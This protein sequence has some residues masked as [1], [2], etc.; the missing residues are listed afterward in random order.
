[1]AFSTKTPQIS[2]P[3]PGRVG[4]PG[5]AQAPLL[6]S[7]LLRHRS[8][9]SVFAVVV[10]H[11]VSDGWST[12]ILIR[13]MAALYE[14]FCSGSHALL[15]ELP[16]QYA[17]FAHWQRQW[18]QGDVLETQLTYW[19]QQLLGAPLLELPTDH[20]RPAVQTF[21][22]SHQS[23][24][25]PRQV[26]EG[27]KTL[28]RQE[29]IT[30]FMTL[31][32]AYQTLLCRYSGQNDICVGVP[33]AG[34]QNELLDN[35][36][37]FFLNLL[38]LRTDL[39]GNP[40][41]VELLGRV[42]QRCLEAYA[43]QD[44]PFERL[45]EELQPS[46]LVNQHPLFQASFALRHGEAC[47]LRLTGLAVQELEI[48]PG[49]SRFDLE[50]YLEEKGEGLH[51][52][53]AGS[54]DLFD[55]PTIERMVGHFRNLLESIVKDPEERISDL[56]LLSEKEKHQLL[57]EWNDTQTEY[58]KDKCLHQLFEAQ[59]EKTPDAIAVV[60]EEQQLTYREL[61]NRANQL[62]HYLQKLGVG[63]ETLVGVCVERSLEMIIGLLGILK[64]GGAYV[65]IDPEF[66]RQRIEFMLDESQAP[67]LLTQARLDKLNR[68]FAGTRILLDR[69]WDEI[70]RES[71]TNVNQ[72][73]DSKG[74]AYLIYTSGS[75]GKPKGIMVE[76]RSVINF[77]ASMAHEPGIIET[78]ILF[79]LTSLSFDI[80]GLEIYLP[81]T[82]GAR[83]VLARREVAVD[84]VRLAKQISDCGATVMQATPAVWRL[85][86]AAG[87][88]G[89][90]EL[91]ILCGGE[92]L[93]E[94]L[95]KDLAHRC[96]SLWNMYGP[97]ETT[98]WSSVQRVPANIG[99]VTLGEPIANTQ[100]Y[101]LDA[102][103]NPVP[104]G[105]VGEIYIGGDGLARGDL[106]RPEL[107]AER[108][109]YH[110]FDREPAQRRFG[111]QPPGTRRR[112]RRGGRRC[113]C[114]ASRHRPAIQVTRRPS[115][116][117][118]DFP[119]VFVEHARRKPGAE[120][121]SAPAFPEGN[122]PRPPAGRTPPAESCRRRRPPPSPTTSRPAPGPAR[123][124]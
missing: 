35:S 59:A 42:R 119:V 50:L 77:L 105:V 75:T 86:L 115:V 41:F 57:I 39:S 22:G 117:K 111:E 21:R 73:Q 114:S 104:I 9:R 64:A 51:G 97:T 92:A 88:Q 17:D 120:P 63:P 49:I 23:L 58:P 6:R 98:I 76:H 67:L 82:T 28:S 69:D 29:G 45:V 11:I 53:I 106:N 30:L 48:D 55:A 10:H 43:H 100:L 72:Q 109:I 4:E 60:F 2:A 99:R 78:D 89:R 24:F 81:L 61:N 8:A 113:W 91:K 1:L 110:S 62:A 124:G 52:F 65:P 20:P 34:R 31:L 118:P 27:L 13:E 56:P 87:W 36:I 83:V 84:G 19:K 44:V 18:L 116:R 68:S 79:A 85:L 15:P 46:R 54:D 107:T 108:F 12:G 80:A 74:L 25:L 94:D 101:V 3:A 33:V 66:P 71:V 32:A 121:D 5:R 14:G 90:R 112:S 16:V 122:R 93:S 123:L 96:A 7:Y 37:G 95:A 102:H 38:A 70:A 26:G 40:T 103:R 47:A